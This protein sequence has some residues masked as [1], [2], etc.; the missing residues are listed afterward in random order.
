MLHSY[1]VSDLHVVERLIAGGQEETVVC[2]SS[3]SVQPTRS[4]CAVY[5]P[6]ISR[7]EVAWL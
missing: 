2:D 3:G 1:A 6:G 4:L 5:V 7:H